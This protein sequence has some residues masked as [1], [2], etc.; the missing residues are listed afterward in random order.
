[1]L[2]L[3]VR[4]HPTVPVDAGDLE[5]WLDHVVEDLRTDAPHA[6]VRLSRL[7]QRV[8]GGEFGIGWLLELEVADAERPAA[9]RRLGAALTDMR[10]LGFQPTLLAPVEASSRSVA[11]LSNGRGR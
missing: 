6:T 11:A 5:E 1:M 7:T 2:Q 9:E 8:P 3:A 4:C 10:L